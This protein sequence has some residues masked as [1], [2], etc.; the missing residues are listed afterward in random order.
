MLT[1]TSLL[2]PPGTPNGVSAMKLICDV[3]LYS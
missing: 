1:G 2:G 3:G